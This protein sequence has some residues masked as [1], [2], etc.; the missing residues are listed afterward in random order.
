MYDLE[1]FDEIRQKI[2]VGYTGWHRLQMD[3]LQ[4]TFVIIIYSQLFEMNLNYG[5]KRS[6]YN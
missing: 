5:F 6:T 1:I 3:S 2:L 4:I